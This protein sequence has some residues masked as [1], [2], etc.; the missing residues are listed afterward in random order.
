MLEQIE[1]QAVQQGA[2]TH[3]RVLIPCVNVMDG[4]TGLPVYRFVEHGFAPA[5]VN[6]RSEDKSA[7]YDKDDKDRKH[8]D[9]KDRKPWLFFK[10]SPQASDAATNPDKT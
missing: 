7:L 1:Q 5:L 10:P 3:F 2:T 6:A 8:K 4:I 9:D